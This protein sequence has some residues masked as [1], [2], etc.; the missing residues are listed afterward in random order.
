MIRT[1]HDKARNVEPTG[2]HHFL[3]GLAEAG[4]LRRHYMQNIDGI[5]SRSASYRGFKNLDLL[6]IT[7]HLHGSLDKMFC[8]KCQREFTFDVN[9][10]HGS[11]TVKCGNCIRLEEERDR[12]REAH[13]RPPARK[14]SRIVGA[15][16]PKVTLYEDEHQSIDASYERAITKDFRKAPDCVIIVG[17]RLQIPK[18]RRLAEILAAK[19]KD[20]DGLVIYINKE[21]A[22]LG[23]K[24][25][26]LIDFRFDGDCDDFASLMQETRR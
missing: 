17:T 21:Q 13:G 7:I 10:F 14:A 23:P 15:L 18:A 16:R 9:C 5:D 11:E 1:M 12:K 3:A 8:H 6:P 26:S 20:K 4:R 25:D 22:S 24:M 2:F 19:S